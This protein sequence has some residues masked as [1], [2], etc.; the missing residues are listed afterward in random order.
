MTAEYVPVPLKTMLITDREIDR[1][2]S[3]VE[4]RK[5][6]WEGGREGGERAKRMYISKLDLTRHG[7]IFFTCFDKFSHFL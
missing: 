1:E 3:G 5:E 4:G 6:E 7:L 2:K